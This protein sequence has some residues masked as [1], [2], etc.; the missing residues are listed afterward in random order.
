MSTGAISLKL[1]LPSN[2]TAQHTGKPNLNSICVHAVTALRCVCIH[3][4]IMCILSQVST[5]LHVYWSV[6]GIDAAAA[7]P[8]PTPP[9]SLFVSLLN[10]DTGY[11]EK[12]SFCVRVTL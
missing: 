10:K 8:T 7:H 9:L 3:S 4:D 12:A 11:L 1:W 6:Q 5:V 2:Y